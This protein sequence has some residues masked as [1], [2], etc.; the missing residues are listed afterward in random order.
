MSLLRG[1]K[2]GRKKGRRKQSGRVFPL[3]HSTFPQRLLL[4]LDD[5]GIGIK[6][7]W[8]WDVGLGLFHELGYFAVPLSTLPILVTGHHFRALSGAAMWRKILLATACR[9]D[10]SAGRTG[11]R[12]VLEYSCPEAIRH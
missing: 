1:Q 3:H 7:R 12:W 6:E 9:P 5:L 2:S 11:R 8:C 4:P 10:P